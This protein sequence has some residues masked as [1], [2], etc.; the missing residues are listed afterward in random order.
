MEAVAIF[1]FFKKH[2]GGKLLNVKVQ[3]GVLTISDL[4]LGVY[5]FHDIILTYFRHTGLLSTA[6]FNPLVS[7]PCIAAIIFLVSLCA[8]WILKHIPVVKKWMV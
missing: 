2:A 3:K 5:V 8:V 7:I 1:L 4:T 6:D